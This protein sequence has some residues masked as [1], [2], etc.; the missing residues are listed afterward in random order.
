MCQQRHPYQGN[1]VCGGA[2]PVGCPKNGKGEADRFGVFFPGSA[3]CAVLYFAHARRMLI[4][5]AN[6][7]LRAQFTSSA[8]ELCFSLTTHKRVL[9]AWA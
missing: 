4:G 8:P 7:T 6:P 1:E 2:P 9:S 5:A 3:P